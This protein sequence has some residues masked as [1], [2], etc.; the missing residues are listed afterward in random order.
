MTRTLQNNAWVKV[1]D[2]P[3][4]FNVTVKKFIGMVSD[5]ILQLSFQK[6]PLVEFLV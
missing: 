3:I 1:Q 5:F 2:T 6:L 4:A